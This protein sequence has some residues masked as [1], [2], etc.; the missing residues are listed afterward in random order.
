MR[1]LFDAS[2]AGNEVQDLSASL[3][4]RRLGRRLPVSTIGTCA[5]Q[6]RWRYSPGILSRGGETVKVWTRALWTDA[7]ALRDARNGEG[8]VN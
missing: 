5:S 8:G 3:S 1:Q 4:S 2:P 7:I 6:A